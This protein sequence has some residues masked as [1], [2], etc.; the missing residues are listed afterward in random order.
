MQYLWAIYPYLSLPLLALFLVVLPKHTNECLR[1]Y[2][3]SLRFMLRDTTTIFLAH[4]FMHDQPTASEV[5]SGDGIM[6]GGF[7]FRLPYIQGSVRFSPA[8]TSHV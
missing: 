3:P 8:D 5:Y 2:I 4:S 7:V 1:T 6:A